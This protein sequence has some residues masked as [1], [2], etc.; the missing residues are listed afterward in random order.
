MLFRSGFNYGNFIGWGRA[1]ERKRH[2]PRVREAMSKMFEWY[3]QG[4]LKPETSH[5]F[6]LQRYRDAFA[7]V[8]ERRSMGKVVLEMP[9]AL[10]S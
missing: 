8:M 2:E 4:K 6:P 3:E 1:D 9:V 10:G 7:A 5:R